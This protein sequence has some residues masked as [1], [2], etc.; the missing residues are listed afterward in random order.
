MFMDPWHV[1]NHGN[2]DFSVVFF[3][4]FGGR[5]F[6]HKKTE[7]DITSFQFQMSFFFSNCEGFFFRRQ[8]LFSCPIFDHK[9]VGLSF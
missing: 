1:F 7:V 9:S 5:K 2:W 8:I 4:G 6:A 3:R